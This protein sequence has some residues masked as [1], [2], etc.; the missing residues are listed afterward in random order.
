MSEENKFRFE[1][2]RC[3]NC[4]TDKNT[5]VNVTY[6]D[7]LRIKEALELNLDEINHILSFYIFEKEPTEQDKKKMVISPVETERGK[8][9]VGLRK[10]PD[11]SCYFYDKEKKACRIYKARPNFCRTFPFSFKVKDKNAKEL[12]NLIE[13]KYTEKAKEYCQGIDDDAPLID[14]EKWLKLGKE[15]LEDLNKNYFVMQKWNKAVQNKEIEP[16]VKNFLR[17]ILNIEEKEED[18]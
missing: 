4:C 5:I 14:K 7:I 18:T 11:D 10:N 2:K 17:I 15:T 3:G 1:C 9:F 13:I 6:N 16:N 8:A 12:E